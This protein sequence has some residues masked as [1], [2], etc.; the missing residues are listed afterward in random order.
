MYLKSGFLFI[1]VIGGDVYKKI[2]IEIIDVFNEAK[3]N[4]KVS[5]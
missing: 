5:M 3:V 1:L 4:F 2:K